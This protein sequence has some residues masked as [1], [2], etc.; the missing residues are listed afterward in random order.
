MHVALLGDSVFDNQSYVPAGR[1]TP[2]A[3]RACL[4]DGWRVTLLAQDGSTIDEIGRQLVQ[5]PSDVTHVVLS[6]GGN[7]ALRD[8]GILT[9]R[10][11][12]VAEGLW[13]LGQVAG[14]FEARYTAMLRKVRA[15]FA[16]PLVCTIYNG[17]FGDPH[18][19]LITATA[20]ACFND[21]VIRAAWATACPIVDLRT[22]CDEPED[23]ANE[24][25]PSARGSDK[26]AQALVERLA[27]RG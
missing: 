1:A 13:K 7:D 20:L 8:A 16:H 21:A 15:R 25:E 3:L 18:L 11:D 19:R 14:A 10:A 4:P 26:I 9:E 2:D 17:N 23:Y 22:I 27:G 24:I 5:L 6:T 12:T